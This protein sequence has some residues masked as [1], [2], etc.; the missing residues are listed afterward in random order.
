MVREIEEASIRKV[1]SFN[2]TVAERI[3][4][5]NDQFLQRSRPM[6]EARLLW[7]IGHD[8]AEVRELRSR[9]G[10][11]SGYLSR[12]LRS[13]ETQGL[14]M[15]RANREDRRVRRASLTR[16][17][18]HERKE[19]DRRSDALASSILQALSARQRDRLMTA[20]GEVER[21]LQA[22]MVSF[23]IE[24]PTS[25]DARW[26]FNQYFA[27][28]NRRFEG[29]FDPGLSI[30]ADPQ[31]LTSPMGLLLIARLHGRPIGCG[32]LKFHQRRPAELKRMWIAPA[33]RGL[34][35]GRRL[36]ER[37]A[38]EAGVVVLRLETNRALSEAIALYKRS[39]Y[40][41]VKAFNAEPYAHHWFEKT[42]GKKTQTG[43]V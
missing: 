33:A 5:L 2:R 19:L 14:V 28:L 24:D 10:I 18:L 37:T 32:A 8:G 23:A 27:E 12:V 15:T 38:G 17:G 6:N 20:M 42:L 41:E 39:G 21:L 31:E 13:L 1:R 7:E 3:G 29:G 25:A 35:V 40:A 36:L 30:S 4:A 43:R 34:G 26:C 22:S 11:D 16:A 9:L